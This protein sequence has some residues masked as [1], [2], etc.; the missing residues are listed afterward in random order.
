M[1]TLISLLVTHTTKINMIKV[2]SAIEKLSEM[3]AKLSL[4]EL[5]RMQL[6]ILC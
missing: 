5:C 6:D 2:D 3:R 1:N 4:L